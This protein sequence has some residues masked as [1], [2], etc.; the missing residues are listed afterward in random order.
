MNTYLVEAVISGS[1]RAF[2]CCGRNCVEVADR[3]RARFGQPS[4]MTVR[5]VAGG[6]PVDSYL[7]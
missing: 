1:L 3:I 7:M 5:I 4:S 2:T 6:K